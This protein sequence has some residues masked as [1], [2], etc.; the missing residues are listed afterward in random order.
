MICRFEAKN[1]VATQIISIVRLSKNMDRTSPVVSF[2]RSATF[3]WHGS[4]YAFCNI[5][6]SHPPYGRKVDYVSRYTASKGKTAGLDDYSV[7]QA[8]AKQITFSFHTSY[9]A[10]RMQRRCVV[11]KQLGTPTEEADKATTTGKSI[12]VMPRQQISHQ[13][14]QGTNIVV[15]S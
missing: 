5:F 15:H 12:P 4:R 7:P 2:C 13:P 14:K 10:N 11:P 9:H 3:S 6:L 8:T 1:H